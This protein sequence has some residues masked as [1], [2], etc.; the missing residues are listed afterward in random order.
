[1]VLWYPALPAARQ[2]SQAHLVHRIIIQL[3]INRIYS[4]IEY[5]IIK[6]DR[7]VCPFYLEKVALHDAIN[8]LHLEGP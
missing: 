8:R 5:T 1:M 7:S 3:N 4:Y 6:T 2:V